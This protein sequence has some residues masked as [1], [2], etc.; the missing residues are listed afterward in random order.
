MCGISGVLNYSSEGVHVEQ[1]KV[2]TDVIAHRGPDGEGQWVNKQKNVG[3]GHRRLSI[4]DL[5]SLGSQPMHYA[6]DRYT[7]TY[8]GE[9]YNYIELR[10]LLE[11]KGYVFQSKTDTEVLLALY[12]LKKEAC[13]QD[14]DG[15]FA[16][17]IWDEERQELFCARDRFGEKPFY[18][19]K[20]QDKFVFA[21]EIKALWAAGIK[22]SIDFQKVYEYILYHTIQDHNHLDRTFYNEIY[23]LE[24]AHYL[25]VKPTGELK[26]GK[27]WEI[28]IN[29]LNNSVSEDEAAFTLHELL[30]KSIQNR[31]RSD[32]AV[33]SSLSGGLDSSTIV[34]LI[35]SCKRSSHNQSSFSARFKNFSRDEGPYI[36]MMLDHYPSIESH[37]VF[38]TE[39]SAIEN[40]DKIIFHQDEPFN[41]MSISAQFEVMKLA[42][43][44]NVT[45]LLDGQGADEYLA[46]YDMY[47]E[48]YY[49][50]LKFQNK[51]L[52]QKEVNAY[53]ELKGKAFEEGSLKEVLKAKSEKVYQKIAHVRRR[54]ISP[55]NEYFLG[56]HPDIVNQYK[57]QKNPIYKPYNLKEHLLLSTTQKGLSE[58]LRYADRNSMANSVEVRLP[59]LDHKIVEYVFSL[60]NQFLIQNAWTKHLLRKA[61]EDKLPKD[62]TWRK[63]KIG[64]EPPQER[65]MKSKMFKERVGDSTQKLLDNKVISKANDHL[66]WQYIMLASYID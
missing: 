7:I 61:M 21:S 10:E 36:K 8:N 62:I 3:L 15:M 55:T 44:N 45:V 29:S 26:K 59:F 47:Y 40:L 6:N 52:Y 30:L 60:P 39:D 37:E 1:L 51:A 56:I 27:Y 18:F 12:D 48:T 54:N 16:F 34:A 38:P 58:L 35:N 50:S 23:S 2:M 41:S 33:G 42:R 4:I 57:E 13:L 53:K 64:Y 11:R 14:L 17:A 32:V 63:D 49:Q 28:G 5:S 46:G 66:S 43:Q 65:W 20:N 9:I 22:K 31:L 25:I 19:F 24:P